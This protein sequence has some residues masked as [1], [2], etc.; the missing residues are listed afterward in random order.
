MPEIKQIQVL[1]S[2]GTSD[3]CLNAVFYGLFKKNFLSLSL[4]IFCHYLFSHFDLFFLIALI[5]LCSQCLLS[6]S[7]TGESTL[8][9]S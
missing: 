5:I 4:A 2:F 1:K 8:L 9:I 7:H 6:S 3:F